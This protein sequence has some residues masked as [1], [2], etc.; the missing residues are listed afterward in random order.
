MGGPTEVAER[1]GIGVVGCGTISRTYLQNLPRVPGFDVVAC[2]DLDTGRARAAADAAGVPHAGGPEDVIGRPD[3]DIV[4]NLTVPAAHAEVGVAALRAGHHVYGE[5]PLARSRAEADLL[6]DAARRAGRRLGSAPDTF[7][8]AGVQTAL[9]LVR[10]GAIGRPVSAIA[11]FQDPGPDRW[12]PAPEFL[13][14]AGAG[15]LLDMGPYY[16][17]ALTM[18]LGPVRRV[19]AMEREGPG[20]RVVAS[21]PRAGTRFAVEVPTHTSAVLELASGAVATAVFSFDSP[22]K[23]HGFLEI[24]GTEATLRLPDPN[25]FDGPLRLCPAGTD[26][27]RE[28]PTTG[29]R[30][31]RGLG[32]A[33]LAEAIAADRQHR[34]NA[35]VAAHVLDVAAA[36]TE[37]GTRRRFVDVTSGFAEQ[38]PLDPAW[39]PGE[40][41]VAPERPPLQ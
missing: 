28:V 15:A 4:V 8:G 29:A 11:C 30:L 9:R 2:G 21:G 41:G 5:K 32:V 39:A 7:L 40:V 10:S 36:V 33:E 26:E 24:G 38:Q 16:L 22:R 17:T 31:G 18:L 27:W 37:S 23:R 19:A 6:A 13:F 35:E 1:V 14:A 12:H 34:A 3:V 25:R 20:E